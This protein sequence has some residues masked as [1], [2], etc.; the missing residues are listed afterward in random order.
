MSETAVTE[1]AVSEPRSYYGQPILQ[2]PTW[3]WEIPAYLF[4]GGL[5]GASA[6]LAYL[7]SVRGDQVTAKRAWTAAL[8]G[9]AASPPLLI[10]DLGR[11]ERFYQML[12][13]F[14]VT[15]PMS[16]GSWILSVSGSTT[17]IAA[18]NAWLGLFPRL[19]R[20]A[21]PVAAVSGLALS[22]YTGALVTNTAVPVWH[23]AR[24][25]IPFVFAAGAA[26]SAGAATTLGAAP[27]RVAAAR[28]LAVGGSLAE[29]TAHTAM[30]RGLGVHAE[31]YKQGA[32]QRFEQVARAGLAAGTALMLGPAR[33]SRVAATAAGALMLT[34]AVA[35]RW[36]IYKAGFISAADPKYVV[37]PQR[38]GIRAGE[39]PGGARTEPRARSTPA[40]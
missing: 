22:T 13:M 26:L 27:D 37:G 17:A 33:R 39:R 38:A 18:A 2:E 16:M 35:T 3:T 10:S 28:H 19:S 15:S 14:K 8:A 36:S 40:A 24:T 31:V 4:A 32:A 30:K 25:T 7:S 12:R 9:I 23:E 20:I 21:R 11:P 29:L 6:G 1:T 34:G 5:A